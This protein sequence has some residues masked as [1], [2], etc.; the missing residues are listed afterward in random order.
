M[1]HLVK[2]HILNILRGKTLVFW[3]FFFPILL[4]CLFK[5]GFGQYIDETTKVNP[6]PVAVVITDEKASKE[7][8]AVLDSLSQKNEDQ[9]F[10]TKKVSSKQADKLLNKEKVDGVILAGTSISLKVANSNVNQSI[11][12]TFIDEYNHQAALIKDIAT[13]H[14]DK[15]AQLT[16]SLKSNDHLEEVTLSG[17]H[18]S[19]YVQYFLAL[20]CMAI[21]FGTMFGMENANILQA[22]ISDLG[23]RMNITP[24]HKLKLILATAISSITVLFVEIILV[25]LFIHF[26]IGIAIIEEPVLFYLAILCGCIIAVTLGQ[27]ITILCKNKSDNFCSNLLAG[28]TMLCSFLSGLMVGDISYKIEQ[29]APIINKINPNN[30]MKDAF[31]SLNVFSDYHRYTIDILSLLAMAVLFT[32][33]SYFI[34]RRVKYAN[35]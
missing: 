13:K 21:M 29:Y 11:L 26:C 10:T 33:I 7:F 25:T 16:E 12:K 23:E 14:P 2:Y 19:V 6:V 31:Y 28:I 4:A 20:I 35:L 1:R 34:T 5:A 27:F 32:G 17:R 15:I 24:T 30:V 9:L 8:I 3:T 22:D 18:F